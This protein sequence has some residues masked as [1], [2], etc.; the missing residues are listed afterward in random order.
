MLKASVA[1]A[2]VLILSPAQ[3]Q[4]LSQALKE[5]SL[6]LQLRYRLEAVDQENLPE[7]A[8]ANTL[9]T[10]LTAK[11]GNWQ[12]VRAVLEFDY[13]TELF[14][15]DYNDTL[16]GN[17]DYPVVA[18]PAG[19]DLNQAFLRY[20]GN[21][22]LTLD[23]GRQRI[24]HSNQRFVGSVGWRQQEQTFDGFRLQ[25]QA[26]QNLHLDYAYVSRVNRIF[27]PDSAAGQLDGKL[28]LLNMIHQ[29][30]DGHQWQVFYHHLDFDQ[31]LALSNQTL[32]LDYQFKQSGWGA[33]LA[34]ARQQEAG[35][36]PAD[37]ST[38]Y[39]AL[40]GWLKLNAVTLAAGLEILGSDKD[41]G[42]ITPLAT[43]H[44]FQGFADKFLSTPALGIEDRWLKLSTR[45]RDVDLSLIYHQFL[46]AEGQGDYGSEWDAQAGYQFAANVQL[47]AKLA[48]Y[49]ADEFATDT[50]KFWLQLSAKY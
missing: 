18:D 46:A 36:H 2:S 45:L 20:K 1:I 49:E 12:G 9:R 44:K 42:F 17:S 38:D 15:K 5:G 26:A 19:A 14:D 7:N 11:S 47:L 25:Y 6:D 32:G 50:S 37:Y 29:L 23:L 39:L 31:A 33:H 21:E 35:E 43:L 34:Y 30:G 41:Q 10:R 48:L 24:L 13:V 40:D 8:L 3:G 28:H 4:D 27:G 16:N 22:G